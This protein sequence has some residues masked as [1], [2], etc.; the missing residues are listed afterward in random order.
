MV[1][2]G[3]LALYD[4]TFLHQRFALAAG[5]M[6]LRVGLE[7]PFRLNYP[8]PIP[9]WWER[10]VVELAEP[11]VGPVADTAFRLPGVPEYA[12]RVTSLLF[13]ERGDILAF[14]K[15]L[16]RDEPSETS[17]A[18]QELL[19]TTPAPSFRIPELLA[20]GRFED[21][22]FHMHQPMPPGGHRQPRS[23]PELIETVV[24]DLQAALGS[25]PNPPGTPDHY[26]PVHRD[27]LAINLRRASDGNLYL[28]DWDNV[29]WGPP[30][31]DE[32]AYWMGGVARE[33]GP[34]GSRQA[35]KV[36]RLLRRRGSDDQIR[37]AVEWRLGHKPTEA[38]AGEQRIR[39]G[40]LELLR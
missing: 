21:V 15:H 9:D 1:A 3:G 24:D 13:N 36:H 23:T 17:I 35:S 29:G 32:L 37:E 25:L 12:Q 7:R 4:A 38:L 39:D 22:A 5:R 14:A 2:I 6:M 33:F 19:T 16:V 34:T 28:I 40:V 18:A 10:W 8:P 26:V 27:F 30:L 31:T 11:V 20:H